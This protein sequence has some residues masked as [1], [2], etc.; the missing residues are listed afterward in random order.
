MYRRW[1]FVRLLKLLLIRFVRLQGTPNEISRGVALGIAIGMTPTFGFQMV[2]AAFWAWVLKE[3][4]VAAILG[5]WITNPLTAPFIYA[6]EYETGR[7]MLGMDYVSLPH[8][9][10]FATLSNLGWQVILPLCVGSLVWTVF[11][12]FAAYYLCLKLAPMAKRLRV[13]R[14]PRKPTS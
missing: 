8:E 4:K 12:W 3:S 9:L 5:V 14:W 7:T 1:G 13:P 11:S 6:L 10:T 2:I